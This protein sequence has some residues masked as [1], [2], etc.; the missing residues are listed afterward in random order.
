[1]ALAEPELVANGPDV[2]AAGQFVSAARHRA[3]GKVDET[4]ADGRYIGLRRCPRG[5]VDGRHRVETLRAARVGRR[6]D[7]DTIMDVLAVHPMTIVRGQV[8]RNPFFV[9]PG[10]F[11]RE[12][13]TRRGG[14]G[15]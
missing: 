12:L 8:V 6:F 7:G 11:L 9:E 2:A 1:M 14:Q 3:R 10:A 15:R 4:E 13:H 5:G